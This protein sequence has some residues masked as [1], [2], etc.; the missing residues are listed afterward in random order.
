L[1][2]QNETVY[3]GRCAFCDRELIDRRRH[4]R[5]CSGRCRAAASKAR[6]DAA[7]LVAFA[8]TLFDAKVVACRRC[9]GDDWFRVE[10]GEVCGRCATP[11]DIVEAGI[12]FDSA[13]I[14][15]H[16]LAGARRAV[17]EGREP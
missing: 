3:Q 2:P 14:V 12:P 9:S 10:D 5:Y 4:C 16:Q 15:S 17:A 11:A 8:V 7:E 13:R 1:G 6:R